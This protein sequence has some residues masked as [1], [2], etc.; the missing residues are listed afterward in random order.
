MSTTPSSPKFAPVALFAYRRPDHLRRVLE[1]L[2]EN[3]EAA[4]TEL[5]IHCDA[6]A[7]P[8]HGEATE[9]TREVA[10]S[11]R[12]F[13]KV[14]VKERGTNLGLSRSIITGVGEMLAGHDRLIVLEDDLVVSRHFLAYMNDGL[15]CYRDDPRVASIHGYCYP[16]RATLPGT[17]FLPGADCWG[18]ATWRRAWSTFRADGSALLAEL[19]ERG[20]A[21]RF[22]FDGTYPYIRMLEDQIAGRNDSW[23]IRWYASAYLAGMHTLYPGRSLVANI[24]F[25]GTGENCQ[26]GEVVVS[27]PFPGPV[28]VHRIAVE[29]SRAGREAFKGHFRALRGTYPARLRRFLSKLMR[30]VLP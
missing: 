12:G 24:G 8:M 4:S 9:R 25:D 7:S 14:L 11:A 30:R 28:P 26:E 5:V 10:R 19:H 6:A 22:D 21:S 3:P 23:A 27:E 16:V 13:G 18:W 15:E 20:E 2:A 17:F 1:A 29:E